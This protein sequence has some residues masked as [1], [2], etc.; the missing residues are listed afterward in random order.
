MQCEVIVVGAGIG[1]LTV[2]AMLAARGV[3][4]CLLERQSH[5]G[6]CVA[7][8]EHLDRT[9]DPTFGLYSGWEPGGVWERVFA[10]LPGASPQVTELEPSFV[11]RLPGG[12]HVAVSS[13]PQT[14]EQNI[15]LAFPD[16]ANE[17]VR[18]I[19][20]VTGDRGDRPAMQ[21]PE[22]LS[23]NFRLFLEVQLAA[24]AQ[25][26]VEDLQEPRALSALRVAVAKMW[27]V[28]GGA[29]SVAKSL[30]QSFK[31]SGGHLRLNSPVLRLAYDHDGTPEGVD[32]LSGERVMATR[33]IIS[34][35]TLWDTY[36]KLVGQS[37]TPRPIS[38]ALRQ[39]SGWG[40]YQVFMT[41][42]EAVVASL[43]AT[44][45]FLASDAEDVS[46]PVSHMMLNI[47]PNDHGST[48]R[49]A[50]LTT[51]TFA[52][53]WFAFHEDA[54]WHEEQDKATL[55]KIWARLG[56]ALPE[57]TGAA[58]VFETATPQTYYEST[59]RKMG[60][61]GSPTPGLASATRPFENLLIVGDTAASA[62]GLAGL[63]EAAERLVETFSA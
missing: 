3:D 57:I 59:R 10:K 37:H 50:T 38:A 46:A 33:A 54:S 7:S 32:L 63:A 5:V 27:H 18:F 23:N 21:L 30:A 17:A 26:T 14:L 35:L 9:F 47:T 53:D 15:A 43:P 20:E 39:M 58:E 36:G 55:E 40:V 25:C 29:D 28:N 6:G 1:G 12:K 41:I 52:D 62:T 61:I 24:L 8:F 2:A 13:D 56:E 51:F 48:K 11:V 44:R 4:V 31:D 49:A 42:D 22:N 34:N 19:R 60:M 45:M 16:C